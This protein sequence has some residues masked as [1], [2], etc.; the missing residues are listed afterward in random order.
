MRIDYIIQQLQV[1]T[2]LQNYTIE[3]IAQACGFNTAQSFSV[4]FYKKTG[5]YPS[6][7]IKKIKR[8]QII[9]TPS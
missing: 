2:K 7:F 3:G 8:Q 9:L 4:A 1:E 6:Y 5:I